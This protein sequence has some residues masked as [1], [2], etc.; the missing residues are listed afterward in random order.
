MTDDRGRCRCCFRA[1]VVSN[2]VCTSLSLSFYLWSSGEELREARAERASHRDDALFLLLPP[3][4]YH[5]MIALKCRKAHRL[6]RILTWRR[7]QAD[8]VGCGSD[9]VERV[10][11]LEQ[12]SRDRSNVKL[13]VAERRYPP[14]PEAVKKWEKTVDDLKSSVGQSIDARDQGRDGI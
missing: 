10:E 4:F 11:M 12:A 2:L 14:T 9:Y 6:V 13:N 3:C 5:D 8:C 1:T 7:F